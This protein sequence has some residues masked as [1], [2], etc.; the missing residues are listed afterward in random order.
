MWTPEDQQ[1][2]WIGNMK[3]RSK[4]NGRRSIVFSRLSI[5]ALVLTMLMIPLMYNP[6]GAIE[7]VEAGK[8]G[9]ITPTPNE[10][11]LLD[12]INEN[13]SYNGAGPLKL[14]TSMWWVAR[15]HSQDMIDYDYFEH[16]SSE[17][18]QFNGASFS[19]RVRNYADYGSSYVGECIAWNSWG[20]DPEWCMDAWKN[21]PGHW[22]IIIDPQFTEIGI[23]IIQGEWDGWQNSALYTADFGRYTLSVDLTLSESDIE[24]NPQSPTQGDT[25]LM[26][27]TIHNQ[28]STDSYPVQ[29]RFYDG[30]PDSGG[31]QIGAN[32]QIPYILIH[33]ESVQVNVTWD[34]TGETGSHDIYLVVDYDDII[35]ESDEGNNKAFKTIIINDTTPPPDPPQNFSVSLHHGWNLVSFPRVV[36]DTSLDLVLDSINGDYD[37]VQYYNS[38]DVYDSW[39]HYNI[40]KPSYMNDLQDLDNKKGFLIHII[41]TDGAELIMEGDAPSSPQSIHLNSGWNLVGYPSDSAQLRDDALNNLVFGDEIDAIVGQD[42]VTKNLKDLEELDEMVPGKGYWIHAT[43]DCDWI[44][45]S[46]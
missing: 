9:N 20:P 32:K 17:Q 46:S 11:A 29:A 10:L 6:L 45:L 41:K 44:F 18:G 1:L 13:R 27:A 37:A 8:Y 34:T 24:F 22:N 25:V 28:G 21:S 42:N 5:S 36:P 33:G 4:R 31:V 40:Q 16:T 12:K 39:K 23:G 19:E 7:C 35:F 14:N 30:D 38:S 26:T 43:S 3:R 15:A 2:K